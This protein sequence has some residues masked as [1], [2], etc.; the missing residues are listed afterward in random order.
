MIDTRAVM[1]S[2]PLVASVLGRKYGVKVEIGGSDAYTDGSTIHLPALP[3]DMP[4][5]MLAFAR[6]FLDHEA[7]HVRETD[8]SALE[9][10]RLTS[11]ELHVWNTFEDYRVE[12]KLAS[13]FPGCRQ[14]F[15]WLIGHIFGS[16]QH[17]RSELS[18]AVVLDW[19]LLSVR[20]WDMPTLGQQRDD[21][22]AQ[23]DMRF[24]GLR[25]MFAPI[26]SLARTSCGTTQDAI[27]FAREI[28][29]V[30]NQFVTHCHHGG[31]RK[32][33]QADESGRKNNENQTEKEQNQE[34]VEDAKDVNTKDAHDPD[35]DESGSSDSTD[36][37]IQTQEGEPTSHQDRQDV[38]GQMA[39]SV[40]ELI[41]AR[42]EDL[43]QNLGKFLAA[44]LYDAANVPDPMSVA[45]AASEP[46]QRYPLAQV[47]IDATRQAT[48][49]LRTRLGGLLQTKVLTRSAGGRRGMLDITRLHRFPVCDPRVFRTRAE[50]VGIDTAVHIL[51]DCSGSMVN[52][53]RLA[54]SACYALAAALYASRINVAVTAFPGNLG[55]TGSYATVSPIIRHGQKVHADLD[56]IPSGSTP[57]GEALWWVMQ[58]M[59]PVRQRRKIILIVSDGMPDSYACAR[60]ALDQ[61]ERFGFEIYGLGIA[62]PYVTELMPGRSKVIDTIAELPNTMFS[63]LESA[64]FHG[65]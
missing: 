37:T 51:L 22:A 42:E 3:H 25:G 54:C 4:D 30:L 16:D 14:N 20:S 2:L 8:F 62:C 29:E 1:R 15:D 13:I 59:V 11:L 49:A 27:D 24:P 17:Q 43:P 60:H 39:R 10:A 18:A 5:Q 56:L 47:Y 58:D 12:H 21:L 61:G 41:A 44:A 9:Q 35:D 32:T 26:L 65:K 33:E 46:K 31:R 45:V 64:V 7:A 36:E 28:V 57:L 6:G 52:M 63:L 53:M 19:L 48:T 40:Q 38:T 55:S 50:R 23:M 34:E